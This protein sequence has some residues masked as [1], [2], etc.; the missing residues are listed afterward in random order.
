MGFVKSLEEI[1][2]GYQSNAVFYDAEMLTIYF[3]T[4]PEVVKRLLPPPLKPA[5]DPL[6]GA[7]VANYPKTNFGVTYLESALFP[8]RNST[9]RKGPSVWP[10]R[11]PA[12]W[13]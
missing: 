4:K 13:P 5:K 11:L 8:W 9:E 7:F 10:C 6:G 2:A 12:T 3:E 1:A